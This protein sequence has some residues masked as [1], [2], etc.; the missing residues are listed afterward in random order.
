[1]VHMFQVVDSVVY[2]LEFFV[3]NIQAVFCFLQT[4]DGAVVFLDFFF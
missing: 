1:M 3:V 4:F 2:D